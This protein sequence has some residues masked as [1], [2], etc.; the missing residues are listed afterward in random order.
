MDRME[1]LNEIPFSI[2]G[3]TAMNSL[4]NK[5]DPEM[6][7]IGNNW[8]VL[9][10]KLGFSTEHI[11]NLDCR[12][13]LHGRNTLK[14]FEDYIKRNGNSVGAVRTA[15]VDME[16]ED[17]VEALEEHIPDIREKYRVTINEMQRH[18]MPIQNSCY[19]QSTRHESL[20]YLGIS[21]TTTSTL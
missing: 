2:V 8:R 18:R 3:Q 11:L 6:S 1:D 9:A 15:L 19:E 13:S 5:L 17:A 7:V 21:P 14:L 16:R 10:E 12:Q 4:A 20:G